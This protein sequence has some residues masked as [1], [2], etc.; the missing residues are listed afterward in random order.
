MRNDFPLI[1]NLTR[2]E[3]EVVKFLRLSVPI[4]DALLE[5]VSGGVNAWW[6]DFFSSGTSPQP[7]W[8]PDLPPPAGAA[9]RCDRS[10]TAARGGCV[11]GSEC[12]SSDRLRLLEGCHGHIAAADDCH[13]PQSLPSMATEAFRGVRSIR[14]ADPA[15]SRSIL[16]SL[17]RPYCSLFLALLE[18]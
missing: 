18:E 7:Q 16:K 8:T 2:I 10:S 6:T 3:F 15:E 14:L 17:L 13:R 12:G 9:L 1:S 4:N 11:E 5:E